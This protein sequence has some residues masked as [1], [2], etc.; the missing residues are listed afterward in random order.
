MSKR[1]F[2]AAFGIG[3]AALAWVGF[4]FMGTSW[5]AL[6]MT[7]AIAGVYLL[8]AWELRRSRSP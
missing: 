7:A 8:G 6:A 1:F 4:G 2:A 3:L 5:L